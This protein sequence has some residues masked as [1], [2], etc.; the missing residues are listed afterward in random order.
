MRSINM[1][2][3]VAA[4]AAVA[5]LTGIGRRSL[6]AATIDPRVAPSQC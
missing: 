1:V 3:A 5:L 2:G 4:L 6:P